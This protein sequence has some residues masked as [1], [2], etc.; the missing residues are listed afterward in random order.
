MHSLHECH[1]NHFQETVMSAVPDI[2]PLTHALFLPPLLS[3]SLSPSLPL[4]FPLLILSS[5]ACVLSLS[6]SLSLSLSPS[7]PLS[8]PFP[9]LHPSL[10]S[11][12]FP[13]PPHHQ[14]PLLP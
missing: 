6:F 9:C 5:N 1:I 12:P 8:S 3:L 11:S 4:S 10:S 13:S 7:L 2:G 14:S